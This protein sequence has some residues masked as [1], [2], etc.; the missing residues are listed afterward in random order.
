[1]ILRFPMYVMMGLASECSTKGY[2]GRLKQEGA[3]HSYISKEI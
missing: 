3:R 1:M 2:S